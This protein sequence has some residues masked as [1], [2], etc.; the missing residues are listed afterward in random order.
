[1][2]E[3]VKALSPARL[4]EAIRD[5]EVRELELRSEIE[6]R[7]LEEERRT[8]DAN[9]AEVETE[10]TRMGETPAG[11]RAHRTL[12]RWWLLLFGLTTLVAILS[13]W[14]SVSWYHSLTWQKALL[15]FS[16]VALPLVG[17]AAFLIYAQ[18]RVR[19]WDL[20]R[21]SLGLGLFVVVASTGAAVFLATGRMAGVNLE[22]ERAQAS[23][24]SDAD[25]DRTAEAARPRSDE[26]VGRVKHLLNILTVVSIALLAVAGEVAAG[27]SCHEYIKRMTVVWTVGHFY[28][29]RDRLDRELHT[30]THATEEVRRSPE[31]HHAAVTASRLREEAAAIEREEAAARRAASLGPAVRWALI[32]TG[33]G[34]MVLLAFVGLVFAEEPAR[35]VTVVL[36]DLSTSAKA[37]EEFGKNV[38]AVEGLTGRIPAGGIRLVVFRVGESSFGL[39]TILAETS[40]R[41]PGRFGEHLE[42]WRRTLL[43][44]WR[45]LAATLR[46]TAAGS[47]LF[48]AIARSALEFEAPKAGKRLVI[49]SDMRHVGRGVNLERP[50]A[51]PVALAADLDRQGLIPR[52][53]GT[54]VFALGAH[55][56]G[57]D[58]RHWTR[59]RTFWTEYFRRAGATLRAFTPTRRLEE[60]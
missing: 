42:E 45:K 23:A 14:W 48:G 37:D 17:W 46:P 11:L 59:L 26:R 27:L 51:D 49:L 9:R 41:E 54:D 12:A 20:S 52:L 3:H 7:R 4:W 28:R 57:I 33:L 13:A 16:L 55:T 18:D 10:I 43:A 34:I 22:E 47:D 36:L 38:K 5:Q 30:N 56:S 2:S 29:E 24:R 25:L 40:P 39:P 31:I 8:L 6:I 15:A 53:D 21:I 60:E 35:Q 44:R 1:M 32:G 19:G 58:E 50:I